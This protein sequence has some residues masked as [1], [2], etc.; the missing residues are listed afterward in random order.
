MITMKQ[1][2]KPLAGALVALLWLSSCKPKEN[3][4]YLEHQKEQAELSIRQALYTG[5]LLQEGDMLDIKV[6]AY[7]EYAVRPFNLHSMNMST[8]S[9]NAINNQAA[10]T[11]PQ[12]YLI[13]R[14]G[15]LV[16]PVIGK[17]FV[18][19][20]TKEQLR[21]DLED[22]LKAYLTDP[23]VSIRQLNFNI[24]VLGEVKQPGQYT[25]ATEKITLF[26][27]LGLAGDMT[28]FAK[29]TQVM[30]IRNEDGI[31]QTHYLD[32]TDQSLVGSPYYYLKQNDVLYVQPDEIKKRS[33][34]V[35]PNRNLVFQIAGIAISVA[36]L[37]ITLSR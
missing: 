16:F 25:S 23:L 14:D 36:T 15:Y 24:T 5:S 6:T 31:E 26:Q 32:F 18:K 17:I 13:D 10:Q 21:H 8:S 28:D 19:G 3:M 35:D 7:D 34:N 33:A 27:A 2:F 29:R 22:R 11:A 9:G 12:G 30:L 4:V 20:M 37:I 1:F